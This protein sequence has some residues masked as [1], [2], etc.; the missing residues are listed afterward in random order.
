M[1]KQKEKKTIMEIHIDREK[2]GLG[3]S[4]WDICKI[5]KIVINPNLSK[6]QIYSENKSKCKLSNTINME[7]NINKIENKSKLNLD[8]MY[9]YLN[10][11]QF[12]IPR[13]G[14]SIKINAGMSFLLKITNVTYIYSG[15]LLVVQIDAKEI[16]K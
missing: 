5:E 6:E 3:K 13:I 1:A 9:Y 15:L 16:L 10:E 2:T 8:T 14:E 11:N 4:L 7:N 12:M